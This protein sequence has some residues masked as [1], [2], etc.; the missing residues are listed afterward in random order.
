MVQWL[1]FHISNVGGEG[2]IPVQGTKIPHMLSGVAKKKKKKDALFY[3]LVYVRDFPVRTLE[4]RS[5]R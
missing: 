3:L 4:Y 2:L 1:R 5:M